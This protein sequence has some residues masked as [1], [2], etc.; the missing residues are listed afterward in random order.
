VVRQ[1]LTSFLDRNDVI[2]KKQNGFVKGRSCLTN[3]LECFEYWTKALDEGFGNDLLY[4]DFR[5]AFDSIP[6]KRLIEK[7]K[8]YGLSGKLLE[9]ISDFLTSRTMKAG[10]R[11][12]FS[13]LLDVLSG[14]PQG[15]VIGPLLF[16]LY[17]RE[18]YS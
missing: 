7:L 13:A 12:S 4:L 8:S 3:L 14:E 1:S 2:S 9:W 5:K 10:L 16:L 17:V 18:R 6:I 11:G 15:S